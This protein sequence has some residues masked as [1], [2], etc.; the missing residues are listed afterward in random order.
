MLPKL[1]ETI[2]DIDTQDVAK[3]ADGIDRLRVNWKVVALSDDA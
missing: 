3:D 2:S 1:L